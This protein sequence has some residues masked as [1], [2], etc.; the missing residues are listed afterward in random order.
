MHVP[1]NRSLN[2]NVEN[3]LE[4]DNYRQEGL[5][6]WLFQKSRLEVTARCETW[7]QRQTEVKFFTIVWR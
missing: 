3:K 1:F 6:V 5:V 7:Q 2:N 4:G